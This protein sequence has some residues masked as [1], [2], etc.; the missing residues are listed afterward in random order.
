[1]GE[2]VAVI[3]SKP[4]TSLVQQV[5]KKYKRLKAHPSLLSQELQ[6]FTLVPTLS[7]YGASSLS[8]KDQKEEMGPPSYWM[9]AEDTY[10][11]GIT[12][13]C[14]LALR[15]PRQVGGSDSDVRAPKA[16]SC[17]LHPSS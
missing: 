1:M 11:T 5:L 15:I 6:L 7:D 10:L 3:S 2:E 8:C 16:D 4:K 17:A 9:M 14:S 12:I 13:L